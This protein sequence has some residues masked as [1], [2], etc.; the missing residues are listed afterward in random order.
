MREIETQLGMGK[1]LITHFLDEAK[2]AKYKEENIPTRLREH[3]PP[4]R[5][6]R[7]VAPLMFNGLI[8]LWAVVI[9]IAWLPLIIKGISL[10]LQG[11]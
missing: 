10:L 6:G 2:K 4:P 9:V 5:E 8:G 7:N 3:Y 11:A 1:N